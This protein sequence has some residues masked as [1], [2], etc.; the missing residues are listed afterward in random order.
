VDRLANGRALPKNLP[1]KSTVHDHLEER[2]KLIVNKIGF[3]MVEAKLDYETDYALMVDDWCNISVLHGRAL[4]PHSMA[5]LGLSR[6][7]Q[8]GNV[9]N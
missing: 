6:Y 7:S 1:P 5:L 9:E 8:Q 3:E 2:A 4:R